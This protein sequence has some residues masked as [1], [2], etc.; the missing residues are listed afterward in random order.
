MR[1]AQLA[2]SACSARVYPEAQ[3]AIAATSDTLGCDQSP[4]LGERERSH[5]PR[6]NSEGCTASRERVFKGYSSPEEAFSSSGG[7]GGLGGVPETEH[8]ISAAAESHGL[9][10]FSCSL[11]RR[12]S[13]CTAD[14]FKKVVQTPA[15][16]CC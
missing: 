6:V 7:L 9:S 13:L 15:E 16:V 3:P 14:H 4:Q 10:K 5:V 2:G 11:V 1:H 12:V 8:F